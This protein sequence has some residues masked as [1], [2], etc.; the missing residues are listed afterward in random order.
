[1]MAK[2]WAACG[3]RLESNSALA[4][5]AIYNAMWHDTFDE[6]A[7]MIIAILSILDIIYISHI[8]RSDN[9]LVDLAV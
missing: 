3:M 8:L 6:N 5:K 9:R 4:V 2:E 1:M 7:T